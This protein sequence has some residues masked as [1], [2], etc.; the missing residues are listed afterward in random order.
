MSLSQ[1]R[2]LLSIL[3]EINAILK[4]VT[5]KTKEIE[6]KTSVVKENLINFRELERV[7]LRYLVLS[8][9]IGL[10]EDAARATEM[11]SRIIILI[12]MAQ[13]SY[14]ALMLGTPVGF[15]MGIASIGLT[16]FATFDTMQGTQL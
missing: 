1:T 12:R 4:N 15:L 14:H 2:E 5:V 10:P 3:I 7:A 8:R 13:M 9:R 11:L 16:S 6:Q